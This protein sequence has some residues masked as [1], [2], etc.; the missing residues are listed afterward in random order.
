MKR[1]WIKRRR[2]LKKSTTWYRKRCVLW[3][4][5]E[6]KQRDNWT[7]QYCGKKKGEVQIHGSHILPEGTYVSMSADPENIIALCAEHHVAG[8]GGFLGRSREPSWHGDPIHFAK[9]FNEKWPGRYNKLLLKARELK[10]VNWEE[11]WSEI[12]NPQKE[13]LNG[14]TN[15]PQLPF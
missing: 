1:S 13:A 3:A 7:C 14:R 11:R 8:I 4:K 10:V 6:A 5:L 12:N 9:W 2:P 15:L